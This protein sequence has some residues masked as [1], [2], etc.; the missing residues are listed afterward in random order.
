MHSMYLAGVT[1]AHVHVAAT[2]PLCAGG[3]PNLVTHA[4]VADRC[5]GG[6]RAVKEIV[7]REWRIV[8]A[9]VADA[10]MNGVMPVVIVVGSLSVP[11]AVVRF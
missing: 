10:I 7:A 4:V 9:R 5:A 2:D 1:V 8:P 3:H 6:V 11:A